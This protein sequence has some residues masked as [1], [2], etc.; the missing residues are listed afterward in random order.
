MFLGEIDK[1][2]ASRSSSDLEASRNSRNKAKHQYIVYQADES[3]EEDSGLES[4]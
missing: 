4:F 3:A 1:G 2:L